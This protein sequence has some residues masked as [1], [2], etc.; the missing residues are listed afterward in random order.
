MPI[1]SRSTQDEAVGVAIKP[2]FQ[3]AP[4]SSSTMLSMRSTG[5]AADATRYTHR[6]AVT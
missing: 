3:P 6:G 5:G 4:V 2:T 1:A